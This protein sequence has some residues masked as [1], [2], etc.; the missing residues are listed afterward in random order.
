MKKAIVIIATLGLAF[1]GIAQE[2][3]IVSA[4]VALNANKLDEA[5]EN[6]DKA[7][8]SPETKEKPKALFVKGETYMAMQV[9][10]KYKAENPYREGAQ[11]IFKL[12]DVKPDYEKE[13]VDQLL[14]VIAYLYYNDGVKAYN[15]KKF[16]EASD[17]MKSVV[18]VHDLGAKRF[19]K[20][21]AAML[22]KFDTIS[23]DANQTIANCAYYSGQYEESIPLLT[24]VKNNPIT[25]TPS[26]YECLIDAD[27]RLKKTTEAHA[28]IDEGRKY[29]PDDVTL[30]NYELNFYI[31]SGKQ[32]E[33]IKKLEEASAKDPKNGDILFNIATTYLDMAIP[34][35]QPKPAN[36]ADLLAKADDAFQRA[37]KVAPDNELINYNYGSMFYN[38]AIEF[39]NQMNAVTGTSDADQKKYDDLKAKR[40]GMFTKSTPYFEKAY[41][42]YQAREKQLK[43]EDLGT[44]KNT[45]LALKEVY[46]RQGKMDK[47]AEMKTKY[48]SL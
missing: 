5:K 48:E 34:K 30:R 27:N 46:A 12:L 38:Q 42:Q 19:E 24:T 16:P 4:S 44:Y 10:D 8:A 20:Y 13:T 1:Q 40:D 14:A 22:K 47:S 45:I 3:Y 37:L 26:V 28:A 7:M 33:I 15:D 25:R 29:F 11:A 31:S 23:A 21:P 43:G 9:S 2:K 41:T 32:D 18:K 35:G 39:N 6:I 17:F 36:S